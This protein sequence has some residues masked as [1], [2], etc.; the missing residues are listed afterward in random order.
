MSRRDE[1]YYQ[2]TL[3]IGALKVI[4]RDVK[5]LKPYKQ[6]ARTHSTKQIR[7]IAESIKTFGFMNPVLVDAD[8]NIIA[9]HGRVAAAKHLGMEEIPTIRLDHLTETER[10]AYVL[11]DNR[12][13]ELAGWDE[14]LLRVELDYLTNLEIDLNVEV[15]GFST[16][17]IDIL[18][19]TDMT[20]VVD[21]P[22]PPPPVKPITQDGDLWQLGPHRLICGDCRSPTVLNQLMGDRTARMVITDPPYNVPIDGHARGLGKTRHTDFAMACGELSTEEYQTF[23]TQG[24]SQLARASEDGAL[25]YLFMDWR[26]MAELL[27]AAQQVYDEYINLC[28]WTK[29]NGGMGSLYRS[30]HELVF[31]FKH[32]KAPHINNVQLGQHGRY[33]TNVWNY[34]GMNSFGPARDEVLAMHP[35]VKPVQLVADAILDVTCRG[36]IVLDGFLGSGT[37]LLATEQTGRISYG[38]EIDPRYVDVALHRWMR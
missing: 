32:G 8:N 27:S 23:L 35:T 16:S 12:L 7:Q 26:H 10:R 6:N 4:N 3:N 17:E 9:G 22:P 25:H 15:I 11:A 21:E 28:V 24:F 34:P 29:T 19:G 5:S 14:D 1:P 30:Q 18:L 31:V 38:V 36:D 13:A 2:D 37:T 33:R 20:T